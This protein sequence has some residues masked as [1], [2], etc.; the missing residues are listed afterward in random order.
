[1]TVAPPTYAVAARRVARRRFLQG[2]L[3][4]G[5]SAGLLPIWLHGTSFAG[6]PLG[7]TAR[8]LVTVF[9][10]GGNDGLSTLIPAEDGLYRAM[11]GSLAVDVGAANAVG[12]GLYLHPALSRLKARYDA[13]QVAL[14]R[15]IGEP[16]K[17]HSH[18]SS[19]AT[20]MSGR[21]GMINL[22]GW[23][24]RYVD[25]VGLGELAAVSIGWG[26]VPLIV[27]GDTVPATSLPPGG[28]LFGA[29]RSEIYERLAM[30]SFSRLGS[31]AA[32]IG[33]FGSLVSSTVGRTAAWPNSMPASMHS[34]P[35][36]SQ[37]S[38]DAPA[39]WPFRNLDAGS[40]STIL[41]VSITVQPALSDLDRRGDLKYNVDFREM[42]ATVIEDWFGADAG[43]ILGTFHP[44]LDLF[45]RPGPGGFYDVDAD[46]YYGPAVGWLA[47][48]NITTGTG[49]GEFSPAAPVTRAQMATFLWRY[50]GR[51]GGAPS[52]EFVDVSRD[53]YYTP[54]VDWLSQ[55]GITTGTGFG[56]FSPAASVTR[57]QMATFLWRLE[58]SPVG[59]PRSGFVD[60]A[61]GRFYSEAIDW[62][63][64][65]GITTG[66]GSGR[67]GPDDSVTRAQMAT[68]LWRLAGSPE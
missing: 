31:V 16:A 47:A 48:T 6:P 67:F 26:E 55:P 40:G 43:S 66:L 25:E 15:G 19:T 63:L 4:I 60:V 27:K 57:A 38:Q 5:G 39:S 14:I 64:Y 21:P 65:R 13:G 62:L 22:S 32:G 36:S 29:D 23:L 2:A 28:N 18:F 50:R 45:T 9:L 56:R 24:G 54:A 8:I 51:P 58:G 20:W 42:Y 1:M 44:K 37:G 3:A 33:P 34:S 41:S 52:A 61:A 53:T 35:I 59:A 11:R 10:N 46:T 30:E 68:F 49:V 17:D 7:V 12:E